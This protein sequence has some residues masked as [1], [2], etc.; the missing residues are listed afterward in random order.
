MSFRL[1][2][3]GREV[4]ARD[5]NDAYSVDSWDGRAGLSF[6]LANTDR[7][8]VSFD[9]KK[10]ESTN[11]NN[12]YRQRGIYADYAFGRAFAGVQLGIGLGISERD[13]GFDRLVF[14]DRKDEIYTFNAR[15]RFTEIE[16]Y[17]FQPEVSL[18]A[19][20]TDSVNSRYDTDTVRIGFDLRSSF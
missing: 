13:Y 19:S 7:I 2:K 20:R 9:V 5:N 8:S 11:D 18:N 15:A 6:Q 4:F 14:L 1:A 16:Y 3:T 10:S 12:D 17:G